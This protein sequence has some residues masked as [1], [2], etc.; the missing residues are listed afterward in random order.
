M[1]RYAFNSIKKKRYAFNSIELL[2]SWSLFEDCMWHV[3][4]VWVSS[5]RIL[6]SIGQIFDKIFSA[7]RGAWHESISW[8]SK[9][10]AWLCR[11]LKFNSFVYLCSPQFQGNFLYFFLYEIFHLNFTSRNI[12]IHFTFQLPSHAS[13]TEARTG[14]VNVRIIMFTCIEE[15]TNI[16]RDRN[17]HAAPKM[18]PGSWQFHGDQ[19]SGAEI[20]DRQQ[21][22]IAI[23]QAI[24]IK[25]IHEKKSWNFCSVP[26]H[27][28]WFTEEVCWKAK[29][30]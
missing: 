7:I 18:E 22:I 9:P 3:Q 20:L 10:H 8:V 6:F 29:I 11:K 23:R 16:E 4:V 15:L 12:D 1:S 5:I 30:Q 21:C 17:S 2:L 14:K 19:S 25:G 27:K 28:D 13:Q 24:I 26:T